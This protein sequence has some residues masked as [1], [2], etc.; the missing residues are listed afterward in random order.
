MIYQ[1]ATGTFGPGPHSLTVKIPTTDYQIDFVCGLAI[2]QLEPNQNSNAYGPDSAEILYT[3]EQRLISADNGGTTPG[4]KNTSSPTIPAPT[5]STVPT[6]P[7]TDSATLSGG[8]NPSGTITFYLFAPGV[9]PN[10]S[11]SNNVYS[12]VVTVS[13]NGTYTTSQGS[14]PGGYVP[15]STGTYQWVAVYSG[16]SSNASATS[17]FGSEPETVAGTPQISVVKTADQASVVACTTVGYT[18]TI[19]N[20]GALTDAGVSLTDPLPGAGSGGDIKWSIDTSGTGNG[21][22]TNPSDFTISGPVGSQTLALSSSFIS[23]G[24]SLSPGQSISVH[25]TSPTTTADGNGGAAAP[26]YSFDPTGTAAAGLVTLGTAG[27]YAVLGLANTKINNSLVTVNGNEGV[28]QGGSLTNMSPSVVTGNVYQY[29]SSEYS[30]PGTLKGSLITSASTLSQN[31]ADALAASAAAKALTATQTF[32]GISTAKTITGNGGLN[33]ININGNISLGST[34]SLILSGSASDVFIVNISG[35]LSINGSSKLG[36]AG[37]VTTNH[38]LWN[39]TGSSGTIQAAV[40]NIWYGT[41]LAPKY[42]YNLDGTFYG[43][44]IAGGSSI[45]LLSGIKIFAGT[46]LTN[47]ATV[48]A[49]GAAPQQSTATI[50][51]KIAGSPQLAVGSSVAPEPIGLL[52]SASDLKT[53]DT[54]VA[55]DGLDPSIGAAQEASIDAAIQSLNNQLGS[56]GVHLVDVTTIPSEAA[57]AAIVIQLS[58]NTT[59]GGV[60]EGVLGLTQPGGNITLVSGWNWYYGADPSQIGSTQY[61]FETVAMHELGHG[62]GLGASSDPNSVMAVYLGAGVARRD[63]SSSDLATIDA[64][65]D[66]VN[67][68]VNQAFEQ[69]LGRAPDAAALAY[70]AGQLRNGMSHL[71]FAELLTHSDE[72]YD[73]KIRQVYEHFLGRAPDDD[74]LNYWLGQY[75]QGMTDELLEAQFIGS[76]EYF[77][78]SGG[79][80]KDWVDHMYFDLLGRAPDPAGETSWVNA[81]TNGMD[82]SV[83]AMGFAASAEREGITVRNDYQTFLGRQPGDSEV[84]SWVSAFQGE[85]TNEDVVA[86]FVGSD[87]YFAAIGSSS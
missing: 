1:Q 87:E 77:Q 44:L 25:I 3:P 7:L 69:V 82:R 64:L 31:D 15:T 17:P 79:T 74:G 26:A 19:T 32:S 67:R 85:L 57:N 52:S 45:S 4:T 68:Y 47:T 13:G 70:W 65:M 66:P 36:I 86:G 56:V 35:T 12:D 21:A 58:S 37:G 40:G 11:N 83:V 41:I 24:D 75:H 18:V 46:K 10:A 27:N 55:I 48:S 33:V 29:A 20:N 51:I 50:A 28:S 76:P 49:T 8:Y 72:Y 53:G 81:L 54:W 61:D 60:A 5:S 30:G 22:G 63:L 39:F 14:N 16:D 42:S 2:N 71:A 6:P 73:N 59:L 62:I 9:T 43:E 23:G 80:N 38:V 34:N 84:S 78:H